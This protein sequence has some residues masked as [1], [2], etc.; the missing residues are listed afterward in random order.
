MIGLDGNL[1]MDAPWLTKALDYLPFYDTKVASSLQFRSE[2]ALTLP[3][4]NKRK[5]EVESDNNEPVV[6]IDDFEGAQKYIP[7]GLTAAQWT[8]SSQPLDSLI[9]LN[10]TVRSLHRGKAFWYQYFIPKI[11]IKE[12]YPNKDVPAGRSNLS[13]LFIDFDADMRGIYNKNPLFLDTVNR[14]FNP[15]ADLSW[16]SDPNNRQKIWGGMTRLFSSFNTNFDTENIDYIEIMMKIEK[17]EQGTKMYVNLGQISEDII[18][19]GKLDTEDGITDANPVPNNIIDL[20]EDLGIDGLSNQR[21]KIEANYPYPL[22]LEDDP[23][24]DDYKFNFNKDDIDRTSVDFNKYN[25]FEGNATVSESGQFPDTEI[26]NI[27]NGQTL[28]LD[29]SYFEYEVNLLPIPEQ[30]PQIAGGNPDA[31]WF[32]YRIPIRKPNKMVGNPLYSNIQYIRVWFKGG[33]FKA[34][35]A[36]W[37][38]V[39]S[40]WQRISNFQSNVSDK[41]SIMQISFVNREENSG[42][43]DYYSMPPGV[44]APRNLT[45]PDPTQDLRLNEQSISISVKNLRYG[46]ERMAVRIFRPMDIFFYKK[47]KFFVHGDGSM[48]DNMV[49][50]AN[51]KAYAFL[52]FGTDSSNYYEYRRP[53]TRGWQNIEIVMSQLTAIKQIR[54]SMNITERVVYPVPGDALAMFAVK[55]NPVLTRVQFFGLGV[56]NPAEQYPNELSTTVWVDELRLLSPEASSDW[57]GL[58]SA[59]VKLADLGAI[60]ASFAHTKPNF[61]RLEERFGDRISNTNWSVNMQGSLE[62]F[63]PKSFAAMRLPITY[64]HAE[65]LQDPEFVANSDINLSEAAERSRFEAY[66]QAIRNGMTQSEAQKI[67][68][69]R[70]KETITRSQTLKIS[71]GWAL[72]GVKLGLPVKYWLI[73]DTFNKLTVGYS[74]SQNYERSP[75]VEKRFNW[76]WKL[77]TAYSVQISD[78]LSLQPLGSIDSI[79]FFQ[80]YKKWKINLLPSN[81]SANLDMQRSRTTEK[82]RYLDFASP[83]FRDFSAT[84]GAQF[85]WKI[86]EGG[87]LSPS[88]D[89]N[90]STSSSLVSYELNELG[91]QRTGREL[92][93][94]IL[95]NNGLLDLGLDFNHNQTVTLNFKPNLPLGTVRKY[96]DMTGSYISNYTWTNPL[97]TDPSIKDVVKNASYNATMRF[98]TGV[99]LKE[100]GEYLFGAPSSKMVAMSKPQDTSSSA[101]GGYF[102]DAMM[103]LKTI[104]LDYDK[105]QIEVNQGN[106]SLNPGVFGGT[107]VSNF[108]AR[109]LTGRESINSFG[110]SFAYQMGLVSSPH[111]SFGFAPSSSFPFF[112][113]ET[114]DGL[115]PPNAIL[116][117]NYNQK[118]GLKLNTTRPLWPGATLELN[119]STDFAYNKTQTVETD[120]LGNPRYTNVIANESFNR[121]YL[122][123]PSVF[124][125]DVFNNNIEHVIELYEQRKK[126]MF[127]GGIDS[128]NVTPQQNQ[129]MLNALTESFHEGLQAFSISSGKVGKFLPSVNWTIKWQGIERWQMWGGLVKTANIEHKYTSI[130][131]ENTLINDNGRQTQSQQVQIGFQPLFGLTMSFD[132]KKLNGILTATL[133]YSTTTGYQLN[134]ANRSTIAR[135]STDEIQAQASY[136]MKGFEWDL[137]GLKLQND[138]EASFTATYQSSDRSTYDIVLTG[139]NGKDGRVLDGNSK[140]IIE[141]RVRYN[142][143]NRVT[144]A[145][146]VRYEGTFTEG[147]AQPGFTS[148]QVGLDIRISIAGGR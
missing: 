88:F 33:D 100:L 3:E 73:D 61:H 120:G 37:R 49:R 34:M 6:Y 48:P 98:S 54:D 65:I 59:S 111:G 18:P 124:W 105:V 129:Q 35:I 132:E 19:N 91:R 131:T 143:S 36:D 77:N 133:K 103:V 17:W 4:P 87:L 97:Q 72:T 141:P 106:S 85:S 66:Q 125:V 71:D 81:F 119:W 118:T 139:S 27:N 32:L 38:L 26:L 13:P 134:S 39:G 40:Q 7:L 57:A 136:T 101:L 92:A 30:N 51:P 122:S 52:R 102:K 22:N 138:V 62:K 24:R 128:A 70:E 16:S 1:D 23:A 43:P 64:T 127:P 14:E 140:I 121:T 142:M 86:S 31:G 21:E 112:T 60:N 104:F 96:F 107:G 123:L 137:L 50:G 9:G 126:E 130:Y 80:D 99:K 144:A 58:A 69:I 75:V 109:G 74:Y 42:P 45:N 68:G 116:P 44:R 95:F 148:T 15:T 56:S 47:L 5:S 89:Y 84:R 8:H 46:D 146:F 135:S 41:D 110:P 117:E 28:S 29:N 113:F 12:V 94:K 114:E 11:P 10:D 2:W 145:F 83:V 67:A 76:M 90:V 115:R 20:G 79:D 82:S 63:A 78:F 25:N 147:A 53:L 93:D 108:W 55:G